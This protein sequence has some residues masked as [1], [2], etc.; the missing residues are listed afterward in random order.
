MKIGVPLF[1]IRPEE[2]ARVAQRAEALGFESVWVPEHVVFP[3]RIASRYPYSADGV[4]PVTPDAPHLDPLILLAHIAATTRTIR[5]GTNVYLLPLR[6]PIVIARAAVSLDVLSGGRLS[7]G[8]GVGWLEEEF[9]AVGVDFATRAARARECARALR[10]LWMEREPVFAG[11][12]FTFGPVYFEP[13]PVQKPHPPLLFGG[14]SAAALRRAAALGDGWYGV[15]HTPQSAAS[16]IAKLRALLAE[17][18]R[19]ADPFECTV[20]HGGGALT[21]DDAARYG[22]AGVDRVVVLPWRRGR[23]AEDALARLA[24]AVIAG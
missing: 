6:H 12:Y 23:E 17:R 13:K 5:L 16:Q 3:T 11:R 18:G 15:G 19:A 1:R 22:E 20:S 14:E 24:D 10:V 2:A 8:V 21:R 4:P 9:R 7:L